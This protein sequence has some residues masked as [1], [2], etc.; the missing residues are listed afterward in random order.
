MNTSPLE[1]SKA[2]SEALS[3]YEHKVVAL[4]G[5]WG[6]GK[7]FLWRSIKNDYVDSLDIS[8]FGAKNTDDI[9]RKLLQEC[10]RNGSRGKI[11]LHE[12]IASALGEISKKFIG[13]NVSD[14]ALIAL[15]KLVKDKIIVIDDIERKNTSLEIDS[16]LGFINEYTEQYGCRFLLILNTDKIQD[17]KIWY[18]LHEKVIDKE[19]VFNPSPEDCFKTA[20]AGF[21]APFMRAAKDFFCQQKIQNIRIIRKTLT[22]I[23]QIFSKQSDLPEKAYELY[24]PTLAF[25]GVC[26]FRGFSHE[27]TLDYIANQTFSTENINQGD[28]KEWN[29]IISKLPVRR[30]KLTEATLDFFRFGLVAH[31]DIQSVLEPLKANMKRIDFRINFENF[32]V[33]LDWDPDLPD[34]AVLEYIENLKSNVYELEPDQ[35]SRIHAVL[36]QYELSDAAEQLVS[37][38]LRSADEDPKVYSRLEYFRVEG[39]PKRLQEF[40]AALLPPP[41]KAAT[42]LEVIESVLSSDDM[43]QKMANALLR[44]SQS[45]Y[46]QLLRSLSKKNLK[47]VV[48]LHFRLGSKKDE[49]HWLSAVASFIAACK[50]IFQNSPDSRLGKILHREIHS[51]NI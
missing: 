11:N 33:D 48:E 13:L 41:E 28:N 39:A 20:A 22:A 37:A 31:E 19:V 3:T 10:M 45:D 29:T 25:I 34:A 15:P 8:A 7:T 21:D 9:K 24:V 35:L 38:W 46:E 2:L 1:V 27:I 36:C 49:P 50:S 18:D 23:S 51:R 42:L 44:A 17:K 12:T 26:H 47:G 14:A 16:I 5:K 30:D 4:S 40:K 6:A 43:T 32:M